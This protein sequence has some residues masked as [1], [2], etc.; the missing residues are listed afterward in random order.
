MLLNHKCDVMFRMGMVFYSVQYIDSRYNFGFNNPQI[1]YIPMIC[2]FIPK[3]WSTILIQLIL[4]PMHYTDLR[5]QNQCFQS[6]HKFDGTSEYFLNNL[7]SNDFISQPYYW[8]RTDS[9]VVL[10]VV[11]STDVFNFLLLQSMNV[12]HRSILK[13]SVVL[14]LSIFG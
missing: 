1:F 5:P 10:L 14:L 7:Q 12:V 3:K 2:G 11:N 9:P 4:I 8:H 6:K 13:Y